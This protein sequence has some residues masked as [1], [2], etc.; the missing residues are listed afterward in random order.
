MR[1]DRL[2]ELIEKLKLKKIGRRYVMLCPFHE[3]HTP[4]FSMNYDQNTYLCFGCNKDG[5]LDEIKLKV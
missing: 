1:V 4:S 2:I 5:L 3:E